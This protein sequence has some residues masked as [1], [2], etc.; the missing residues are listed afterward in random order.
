MTHLVPIDYDLPEGLEQKLG[1]VEVNRLEVMLADPRYRAFAADYDQKH[2]A[3]LQHDWHE[4][5][6]IETWRRR[7]DSENRERITAFFREASIRERFAVELGRHGAA[8]CDDVVDSTAPAIVAIKRW[9]DQRRARNIAVLAGRPGVGKTFA[10]AWW[11][12]QSAKRAGFRVMAQ[13]LTAAAFARMSRY[14]AERTELLSNALVLD[15][16]GT[17]YVDAKGSLRT[18]IDE[19]VNEFYSTRRA[20]VITTN[21]DAKELEQRYGERVL[22]RLHEAA[23]WIAVKG[24]SRRRSRS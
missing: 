6:R 11:R 4:R 5:E 24:E 8:A 14:G 22:D 15:D 19:L 21:L 9:D 3:T 20:L 7:L 13:W 2:A 17:E 16:L 1:L 12:W 10:A 23:V 18:D